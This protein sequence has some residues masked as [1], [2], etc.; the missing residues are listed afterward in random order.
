MYLITRQKLKQFWLKHPDAEQALKAWAKE[1]EHARWGNPGDVK[2]RYRTAD[3]IGDNRVVFNING[4]H[5]RLVVKFHY[6]TKM[7]YIRF[8]GTHAEYNKIN[9]EK[10]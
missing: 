5:Y 8:I 6:N 10:I 2:A 9:A 4:N 3:P 1:A 7:A